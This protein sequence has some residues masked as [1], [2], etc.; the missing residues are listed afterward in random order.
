MR[1]RRS[2]GLKPGA[3]TKG[4]ANALVEVTRYGVDQRGRKGGRVRKSLGVDTEVSSHGIG[5]NVVEV[6]CEVSF[7]FDSMHSEAFLPDG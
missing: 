3:S 4:P 5:V 7:V 6:G 1:V 2:P